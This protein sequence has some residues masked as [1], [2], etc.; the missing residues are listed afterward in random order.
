M[1]H[2][3]EWQKSCVDE[4]LTQLNVTVL[5]GSSPSEYL[6][7]SDELPRRNDGRISH[8]LLKRYEHIESGGWWCSGID[9]LTGKEDLWGCFKPNHPRFSSDCRKLIK[10]E[11]PPQTP[12]GL[13]ALR[14]PLHLWQRIAERYG[15]KILPQDIDNSQADLGF[16]QWLVNHPTIPLCITEGAKKAG[17]LL[18][19]GYAAIALPG[20]NNGY[21][22]PKDELG[23]CIGKSRLIPQLQKLA[24]P[25]R[26]IYIVFDQ[27]SKSKTIQAVNAAIRQMGYLLTQGSCSVKVIVWN[28]E[29]GKGVDDLILTGGQSAFDRAYQN[30][31]SLDTWKAQVLTRLTYTPNLQVNCRYLPELPIPETAKLIGIKSPKGT[32][33]TQF[34]EKVVSQA[35]ARNQWVLVIGHRV[36]LVEELCQRFGLN[37]IT[38]I[39]ESSR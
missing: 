1:N 38:E 20:I 4:Q 2:L 28:P 6:L 12:T 33:K 30:A 11:H 19:A 35:L 25:K 27:D 13:F 5:A 31:L 23:H 10:Y 37:Y 17:A 15:D 3:L 18:T 14:V 21:R 22:V 36:R 24:T 29:L 9:L 39:H 32:G 26:E 16:W 7:Y 34:L 8:T